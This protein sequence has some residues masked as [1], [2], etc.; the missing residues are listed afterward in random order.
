MNENYVTLFDRAYL[1]QGIAL[2]LSMVRHMKDFTLWI[3]CVDY[4]TFELFNT[5]QL[6]NVRL[7]KSEDFETPELLNLKKKRTKGEYCWTLTPYAP[8]IVFEANSEI[9]RVTYIDADI[10][11]RKNPKAIFEE[12]E[13]S[14]KAI[15]ITDHH[16]APEYDQSER[17]G[18]FCVQLIIFKRDVSELV[19]QDWENECT[20]WCYSR[21]ENGKFGDQKYLDKWPE[22]YNN[23]VHILSN[24]ELALAPWNAIRFPYGQSVFFHFHGLRLISDKRMT[25][26]S[27]RIPQVVIDNVYK[28]YMQ[29]IKVS[30]NIIKSNGL[31][32]TVQ[33]QSNK[34]QRLINKIKYFKTSLGPFLNG[35]DIKIPD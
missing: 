23:L 14:E 3:L 21:F 1:P 25:I 19:R 30:I 32:I 35:V 9:K 22:K 11:F 27:Y 12:F 17:S 29:D 28:K 20:E 8:K 7:L 6:K 18:Q 4:E 26:G 10:W 15:L 16:Y 13:Q 31:T 33:E 2:Y 34:I 24:K 5:L